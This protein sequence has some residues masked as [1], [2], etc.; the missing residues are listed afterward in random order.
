MTKPALTTDEAMK[1]IVGEIESAVL[2][3]HESYDFQVEVT[4]ADAPAGE[5]G[6]VEFRELVTEREWYIAVQL[7]SDPT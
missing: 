1:L 4:Y 5:D 3:L 6:V 7:N 2:K